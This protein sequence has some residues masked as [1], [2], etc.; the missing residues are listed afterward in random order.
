[1]KFLH[2][3]VILLLIIGAF[4]WFLIGVF[5]IDLVKHF[6]GWQ[7]ILTRVIYIVVGL[8][9]FYAVFNFKRYL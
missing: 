7:T 9:G 3:V 2:F 1:M 6:F 5:D 4:N 8:A